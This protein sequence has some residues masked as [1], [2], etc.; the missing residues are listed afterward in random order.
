M[1]NFR[2]ARI[3]LC[4]G[5]LVSAQVGLS[6]AAQAQDADAAVDR[7]AGVLNSNRKLQNRDGAARADAGAATSQD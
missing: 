3:A 5:L 7:Y 2:P 4:F 6:T 1:V